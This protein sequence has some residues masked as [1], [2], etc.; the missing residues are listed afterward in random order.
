MPSHKVSQ[1]GNDAGYVLRAL[2]LPAYYGL[3]ISASQADAMK[4]A[5]L[6]AWP[7]EQYL[8]PRSEKQCCERSRTLRRLDSERYRHGSLFI[9]EEV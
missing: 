7:V 9:L 2:I 5:R 6:K 8:I 1:S 4:L 3:R